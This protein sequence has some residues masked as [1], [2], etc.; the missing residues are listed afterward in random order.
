VLAD[1]TADGWLAALDLI[2]E[3]EHGPDSSAYLVTP[4]RAVAEAAI[5]AIPQHWARMGAER[6]GYSA[7]CS[8]GRA[9]GC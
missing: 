8:E 3:S 2:V 9:A 4:S 1:E 6:V 5:A 7:P